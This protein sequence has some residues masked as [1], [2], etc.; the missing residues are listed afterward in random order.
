MRINNKEQDPIALHDEDLNEVEKF[1]YLGSVDNKDG[2]Q[3]KTSR[4]GT[5]P[6]MH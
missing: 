3:T 6:D 2:G 4:A 1:V 5:R